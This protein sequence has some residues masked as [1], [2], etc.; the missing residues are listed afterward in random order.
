VCVLCSHFHAHQNAVAKRNADYR[1]I[2]SGLRFDAE[3]GQ[4]DALP[5]LHD[6]R[7]L[8]EG[9]A[10]CG[11]GGSQRAS[12]VERDPGACVRACVQRCH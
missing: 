2:V 1:E 5:W 7:D 11:S 4:E 8:E 9:V 10:K 3:N 6:V 12:S